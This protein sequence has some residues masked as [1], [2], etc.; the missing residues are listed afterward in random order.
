MLNHARA[1]AFRS[2]IFNLVF[3]ENR[4]ARLLWEQ[5]NFQVLGTLPQAARRNDGSYQDA[6]IMFRSLVDDG[7]RI[8]H[9]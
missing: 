1:L 4:A 3:A 7:G 6:L 5:L 8:P 9:P 2:L